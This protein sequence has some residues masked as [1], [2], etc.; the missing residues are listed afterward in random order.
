MSLPGQDDLQLKRKSGILA[1]ALNIVLPGAGYIYC[2]RVLLGVFALPFILL[3]LSV[4][5]VA[6]WGLWVILFV[7]GFLSA[8]NYNEKLFERVRAMMKKCP[9][10]A[11]SVQPDALVCKHCGHS[12]SLEN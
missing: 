10:C 3:L 6:A 8:S 9:M 2:G 12:F 11:E 1:A 5:Q 7:D 4:S